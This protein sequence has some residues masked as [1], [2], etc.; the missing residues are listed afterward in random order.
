M[1]KVVAGFLR[2]IGARIR[3]LGRNPVALATRMGLP[4]FEQGPSAWV[5]ARQIREYCE[6]AEALTGDVHLGLHAAVARPGGAFGLV[7][8][9]CRS[10]DTLRQALHFRIHFGALLRE[11]WEPY[12]TENP[13]EAL[14]GGVDPE[15][16]LGLGR[17]GHEYLIATNCMII[18]ENLSPSWRPR[19]VWFSHAAP[20][21]RGGLEAVFQTEEIYF[22]QA[23]DGLA[24]DV[25]D[26]GRRPRF[27]DPA[28]FA[29]LERQAHRSVRQPGQTALLSELRQHLRAQLATGDAEMET[30]AGR[31]HMSARTLHRRLA[32]E[33]INYQR[34]LDQLRRELAEAYAGQS[35]LTPQEM[36]RRLAY[37]NL[38]AFLRAFKRWTGTSPTQYRQKARLRD[39]ASVLRLPLAGKAREQLEAAGRGD[40]D[41]VEA[42]KQDTAA[43]A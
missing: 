29:Y 26:L 28:L 14:Y 15:D 27:A 24:I 6:Q 13:T 3:A 9:A 12:L 39:A 8:F 30:L 33:G 34:L 1:R 11:P 18:R 21:S 38:P 31:F 16:R 37:S 10:A 25:S 36:S 42:P 43:E 19:R 35:E 32:A 2:P 23:D 41:D 20:P 22:E 4:D 17:H 40:V 7:E 5:T